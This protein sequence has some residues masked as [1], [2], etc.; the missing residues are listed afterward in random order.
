MELNNFKLKLLLVSKKSFFQKFSK[1][2]RLPHFTKNIK[3]LN[4]QYLL[5]FQLNNID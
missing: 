2:R 3:D 1:T 5:S 4:L